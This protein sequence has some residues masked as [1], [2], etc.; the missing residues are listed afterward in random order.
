MTPFVCEVCDQECRTIFIGWQL[1]LGN[2]HTVIGRRFEHND[3]SSWCFLSFD[4][5]IAVRLSKLPVE[6]AEEKGPHMSPLLSVPV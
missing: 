4:C 5:T 6:N 2:G 1:T 3:N